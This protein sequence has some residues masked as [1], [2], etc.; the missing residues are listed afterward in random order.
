LARG[1]DNVALGNSRQQNVA[2][3]FVQ[4]MPKSRTLYY[5]L[6]G[7]TY[8]V[9]LS[10]G[11]EFRESPDHLRHVFVRST[12]NTMV[13]LN[14]LVSVSRIVAPDVVYLA[15]SVRMKKHSGKYL[16]SLRATGLRG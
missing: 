5:A 4:R 9:S 6:F 2:F 8:R 16:S 10:S 15:T 11:G 1:L 3:D 7:R 13:P 14:V 12:N